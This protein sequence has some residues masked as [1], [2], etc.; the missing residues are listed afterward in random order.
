MKAFNLRLTENG[1]G[2]S[3]RIPLTPGPVTANK[4]LWYD[5]FVFSWTSTQVNAFSCNCHTLIS[6]VDM[7]VAP[8]AECHSLTSALL[9]NRK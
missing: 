9:A 2:E 3:R 7:L 8:A 6:S 5:R 4:S 1:N